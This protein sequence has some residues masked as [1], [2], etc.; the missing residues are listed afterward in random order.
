[1]RPSSPLIPCLSL[2][3]RRCPCCLHLGLCEAWACSGGCPCP[4]PVWLLS[5]SATSQ[6]HCVLWSRLP[7]RRLWT[8]LKSQAWMQKSRV[9]G[10]PVDALLEDRCVPQAVHLRFEALVITWSLSLQLRWWKSQV[11]QEGC[12]CPPSW[13]SSSCVSI[14][15]DT[16]VVPKCPIGSPSQLT[17]KS[18]CLTCYSSCSPDT[19][20]RDVWLWVGT[21]FHGFSYNLLAAFGAGRLLWP[22]GA[23]S[24]FL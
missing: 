2:L 11:F 20:S 6:C 16:T 5:S 15:T 8:W 13:G 23:Y 17:W 24:Y 14:W 21:V 9:S 7:R 18:F 22:W 3:W 10:Q 1:M 19:E 12:R 4:T